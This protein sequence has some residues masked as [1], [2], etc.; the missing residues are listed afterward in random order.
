MLVGTLAVLSPLAACGGSKSSTAEST[1]KAAAT[2]DSTA[3]APET[4]AT[5]SDGNGDTYCSKVAQYKTKADSMSAA[6]T[7]NNPADLKNA[8]ETIQVMIHDLDT[9][10]PADIAAD[11]HTMRQVSDEIVAVFR[12]YDYDV[13]KL[14]GAPEYVKLAETMDSNAINEANE[15]LDNYSTSVCGLPPDTTLAS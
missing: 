2:G 1:T 3:A 4:T 9:D 12:K 15:K 8:F 7:S 10:P 5:S 11:V 14:A 13:T 6:M